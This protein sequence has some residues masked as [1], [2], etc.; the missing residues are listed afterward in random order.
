[1]RF[2]RPPERLAVP[3]EQLKQSVERMKLLPRQRPTSW[4]GSRPARPSKR[5]S[6]S[7][8]PI[9]LSAQP[10]GQS[11]IVCAIP[12]ASPAM[13]D[14]RAERRLVRRPASR[15]PPTE[16]ALAPAGPIPSAFGRT[17]F[18]EAMLDVI[19]VAGAGVPE[20]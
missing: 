5:L 10:E 19:C 9:R 8:V 2:P 20:A 14:E 1:M 11:G 4:S 7:T 6:A 13:A 15:R 18:R 12:I 17:T 16:R 3:A